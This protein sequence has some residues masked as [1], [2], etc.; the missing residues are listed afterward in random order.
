M[1]LFVEEYPYKSEEA[2]TILSRFEPNETNNGL[3]SKYVGYCYDGDIHDCIFF[4]PKVI[5]NVQDEIFGLK[6]EQITPIQVNS[7]TRV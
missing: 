4:L 5:C 1:R 3:S 2:R 6:P 7:A